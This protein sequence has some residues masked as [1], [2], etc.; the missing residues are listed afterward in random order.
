MYSA[1]PVNGLLRR[2]RGS[3][4]SLSLSSSGSE[5]SS[6]GSIK[7][8]T[9][10]RLGLQSIQPIK[11]SSSSLYLQGISESLTYLHPESPVQNKAE[12]TSSLLNATPCDAAELHSSALSPFSDA[13]STALVQCLLLVAMAMQ[14]PNYLN[15]VIEILELHIHGFPLL[16]V[17]GVLPSCLLLKKKKQ[18]AGDSNSPK[19]SS[20]MPPNVTTPSSSLAEIEDYYRNHPDPDPACIVSAQGTT[21]ELEWGHFANLDESVHEEDA[22]FFTLSATASRRAILSPL[23]EET[24]E[25]EW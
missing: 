5:W 13:D 1:K 19:S 8:P 23:V 4:Q 24:E 18:H 9:P 17:L 21:D 12:S 7:A 22:G 3:L 10:S 2:S 6:S 15:E 14:F 11:R 25:E 20:S 16:I